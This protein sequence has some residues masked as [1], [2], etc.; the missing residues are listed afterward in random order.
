VDRVDILGAKSKGF[1]KRVQK[2]GMATL[3]EPELQQA[4][5]EAHEASKSGRPA[6][7]RLSRYE[8][9]ERFSAIRH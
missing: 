8:L 4:L 7:K 6:Q 5:T 1:L 3:S 2:A 9:F